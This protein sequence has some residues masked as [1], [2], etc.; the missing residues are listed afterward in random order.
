VYDYSTTPSYILINIATNAYPGGGNA[1]DGSS[2]G[3]NADCLYIDDIEMIYNLHNL[4]T[5]STGWASLYLGYDAL[6]PSGATAYTVTRLS[7]G[8][9]ALKE[10][11]AGTV[12]PAGTGVLVKGS[13][14]STYAFNGRAADVSGKTRA[15]VRG[16]LLKGSLSSISRPSGTCRV[17]S[18]ESSSSQ[19]VLGV[20][21]GAT[22]NA[23][24][25][26]LTE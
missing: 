12:I 7:C 3:T 19:A 15:D 11:P 6:V 18:P 16:N 5:G 23:N 21:Q 25:A 17:L 20:F 13:A 9:A 8:Y 22:I 24:T 14:N 2:G 4:R 1:K 10:I 26:Y